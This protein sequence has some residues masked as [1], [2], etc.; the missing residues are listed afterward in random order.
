MNIRYYVAALL[1][2]AFNSYA[3]ERVYPVMDAQGRVQIIK[4]EKAVN[5]AKADVSNNKVEP[6]NT[7]SEVDENSIKPTAKVF[8]Q[9]EN[10]V[11][12]DSD[13]L[14]KKSFNLE[15]KKRFY[16]VPNGTGS[17]Q[18]MESRDDNIATV[19]APVVLQ[20]SRRTAFYA[21]EYLALSKE[22]LQKNVSA[23]PDLCQKVK[24]L[25]K[26]SQPFKES[27][28][29]WLNSDAEMVRFD[30]VL[31]FTEST[32]QERHFR[33]SSFASTNKN[34]EFY[35]PIVIFLDAQG[36][37][38]SGAW[39]YWSQAYP[40]SEHHFSAVEGLLRV[41]VGT[42]YIGLSRPVA[43]LNTN[44]PQKMTGSL[45]IETE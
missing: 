9:L 1:G 13:Y 14:E 24:K 27:N 32:Q 4:S 19:P 42:Q 37:I 44:L 38:L 29:L 28:A 5:N 35:L 18:L 7:K 11:Y 34:P 45:M 21:D 20:P 25:Q 43:E 3:E 8:Q 2:V 17:Q 26:Y 33:I 41:P 10:E 31:R 6:V 30:R 23:M 36:C 15:D 40:A 39:N 16:Y 12:V 22:W